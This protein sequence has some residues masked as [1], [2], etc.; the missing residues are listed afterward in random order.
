L[1]HNGAGKTTTIQILTGLLSQTAGQA[2]VFGL[3]MF[4]QQDEVRKLLGVCPQHNVLFEYL[5]VREHL[6][7]YAAFRGLPHSEIS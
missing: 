4:E 3:D 5:S 7:L 1:G 2:Q 6:E